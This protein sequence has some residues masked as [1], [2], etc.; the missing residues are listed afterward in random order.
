MFSTFL[1]KTKDYL[2]KA[3]ILAVWIP[4]LIFS[5]SVTTVYLAET[6]SLIS[7]WEKWL[8]LGT[9][10][11]LTLAFI[12]L[13]IITLIA[14]IIH[15]L[16]VPISR[17]FEGYRYFPLREYKRQKYKLKQA[18]LLREIYSLEDEINDIVEFS[19]QCLNKNQKKHINYYTLYKS[20][21]YAFKI[22]KYLPLIINYWKPQ[23][24]ILFFSAY[25]ILIR[26]KLIEYLNHK[27]SED[28]N[29]LFKQKQVEL[30]QLVQKLSIYYPP[31][32][33]E[34]Q[35]MPT[36]LGNI[37]KAAE[38]YAYQHY[39]A[40]AVMLW[41]RIQE[42]LPKSF[43]NRLEETKIATDFFLLFSLLCTLFSLL[44][45]PY[46]IFHQAS[47]LLITIC[48]M[49]ILLGWLAYKAALVPAVA[50]AELIKVAYDLYR[51][52]LIKV[53]GLQAPDT[54]SQ[55][56]NLWKTLSNFILRGLPLSDQYRFISPITRKD[57][58]DKPE[59]D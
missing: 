2:G 5:G 31:P 35:I 6:N 30:N 49:G 34:S 58:Q 27:L 48:C 45:V 53:F 59:A 29:Q 22:I 41:T 42:V 36:R 15:Y 1:A 11:K 43:V 51:R 47:I 19:K 50:Y 21:V 33:Y 52:P 8:K 40:D 7:T 56:K 13:V 55:E 23:S 12:S 32:G 17:F 57:T 14:F 54:L 4:V 10:T 37:Y 20:V 38:I 39:G 25:Q 28:L 26:Y 46:L 16:Q 24:L 18:K 9:E 3:F 44:T